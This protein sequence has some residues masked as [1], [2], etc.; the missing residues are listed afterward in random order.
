MKIEIDH[1][2]I[3]LL[4]KR[5]S[6]SNPLLKLILEKVNQ[7]MASNAELLTQLDEIKAEMDATTAQNAKANAEISAAIGVNT[8][9]VAALT[10]QVADLQAIIAAGGE[11]SP[12]IVAKVAELKVSAD[13][14][15]ASSQAL[16][17]LNP[18]TP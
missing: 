18:D 3:D 10:Q 4:I 1:A 17:D 6:E 2:E 15:K 9:T 7:I 8:T 5:F 13:A 16:D 11:V 12:D 14:A